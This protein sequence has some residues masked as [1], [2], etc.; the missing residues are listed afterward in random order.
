[1]NICLPAPHLEHYKWVTL[2]NI[3][4]NLGHSDHLNGSS[5]VYNATLKVTQH[6]DR[7]WTQD[8]ET[9]SFL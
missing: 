6:S 7:T 8:D 9:S 3:N 5:L 1:M 4:I 2:L